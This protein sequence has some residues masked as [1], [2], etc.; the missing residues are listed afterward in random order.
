M[1][2]TFEKTGTALSCLGGRAQ[3]RRQ[4]G[5]PRVLATAHWFGGN[6]SIRQSTSTPRCVGALRRHDGSRNFRELWPKILPP[7]VF[8][9][10]S[11]SYFRLACSLDRGPDRRN[12]ADATGPGPGTNSSIRLA[13]PP[14][15]APFSGGVLAPTS[16]AKRHVSSSRNS[17]KRSRRASC[18]SGPSLVRKSSARWTVT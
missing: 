5:V 9:P 6:P 1:W 18:R 14:E 16:G 17:F 15:A 11:Q 8:V 2:L 10:E 13:T 4:I 3:N 7:H 12:L